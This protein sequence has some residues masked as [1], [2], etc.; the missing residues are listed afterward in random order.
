MKSLAD[1][2]AHRNF[3]RSTNILQVSKALGL[4][5]GPVSLAELIAKLEDGSP[6]RNPV[7][8]P[9]LILLCKFSNHPEEP[10]SPEF[11]EDW[12]TKSGT[13]GLFDYW[14]DVTSGFLNLGGSVVKGWFTL[15][16]T[17]ED[18]KKRDRAARILSA[19]NAVKNANDIDLSPF[20]GIVVILN[21]KVDSGSIG[22][23]IILGLNRQDLLTRM[24]GSLSILDQLLDF[25]LFGLLVLDPD[26]W[27]NMFAAHEMGHGFGLSHSLGLDVPSCDPN[28][29]KTQGAYCDIW[30]IMS[31]QN[32]IT[33][34]S[35]KFSPSGPGLNAPNLI[36]QGWID[37]SRILNLSVSSGS[38]SA[39]PLLAPLNNPG[40]QGDLV[41]RIFL[42]DEKSYYTIEFHRAVLWDRAFPNDTVL[43]HLVKQDG[44][45]YLVEPGRPNGWQSGDGY[46]DKENK[47]SIKVKRLDQ[48]NAEV[49]ILIKTI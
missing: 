49:A 29:D 1:A 7:S 30:D 12:F 14:N 37:E 47:I 27:F 5:P 4:Y 17:L 23:Q 42:A 18:D 22:K 43:L 33:F 31:A 10:Q 41:V 20:D 9:W 15:P 8:S 21:A 46:M 6:I 25:K 32:V 38:V 48:F 45:S 19:I 24:F 26:A 44:R 2:L 34:N 40:L 11:F 39:I 13:G 3:D 36:H 28:N 35:S 16:Y